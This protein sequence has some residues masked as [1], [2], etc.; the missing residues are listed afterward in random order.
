MILR[1]LYT[2][3]DDL[4]DAVEFRMG[5]NLIFGHKDASGSLNGIG[6]STFLD[7][8]DF[9]LLSSYQKTNNNRLFLAFDKLTKHDITLEFETGGKI[10]SIHRS[11]DS[12]NDIIF[13]ADGNKAAT[14][15]KDAKKRL[16]QLIFLQPKYPGVYSD[17]WYRKLV[18]LFLKVHKSKA[19]DKFIDPINYLD[20]V[21]M[22]ELVQ[23]HLFLLGIDNKLS[24][25][26]NNLQNDKKTKL[27]ALKEVRA[28]VEE[29]YDV[30]DIK[31]ANEQLLSLQG[32]IRKL[33]KAVNAF[34][35]SENY[36]AS[37]ADVDAITSDIK[38]LLLQNMAD[39][40][41]L[42]EYERSLE[43]YEV[44]D[45][46]DVT[47][48]AKIYKELNEVFSESVKTTLSAAVDFRRELAKS[49]KEFI[50]DEI[51]RLKDVTQKRDEEIRILDNKRAD[52]LGFL[53]SREAITDLTEA[54][55]VLSDKKND[56]TDLSGKLKTYNTLEKEK[57]EIEA[58]EKRN[59]SDI[60]SFIQNIQ[61]TTISDL[62]ELFMD[63]YA[64]VYKRSDRAKFN[65]IDKMSTDAKVEISVEIP[66]DN[67]KANNQG[68]TL[69]YDL[70][71][72]INMIQK[73]I[74]GPRFIVH[75]GIFDGMDKAHFVQLHKFLS[76]DP[77]ASKIQYIYTL[78]EEGELKGDFGA[79]DEVNIDHLVHEA[80][81]VLTPSRKLLGDF[82]KK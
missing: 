7:L 24:Y 23:Y 66:A 5:S 1:R 43:A 63:V 57:I 18:S 26:N 27:P 10:Y 76:E 75:D 15:L 55:S 53:K 32:E 35:L 36:R 61:L 11:V 56:L 16:S 37:E 78:N 34:K 74:N 12:P 6:K 60:L 77:R 70:M 51:T 72:L 64:T 9:A 38:N 52:I 8:L 50:G 58:N 41:R 28:I 39:H 82:D 19:T 46:R 44:F 65:I 13:E 25:K 30:S 40:K 81:L 62:H 14:T 22:S 54:F 20:N 67:S 73:E 47:N 69:I 45:K 2:T 3:P 71:L 4:F 29:T 33:E 42:V 48:V 59:D 21:P 79:T 31:D 68:R 80:I 49:R 17:D